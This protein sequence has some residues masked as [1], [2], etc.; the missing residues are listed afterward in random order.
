MVVG[1]V[2]VNYSRNRTNSPELSFRLLPKLNETA[3]AH[4]HETVDLNLM[5]NYR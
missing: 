5:K 2:A 4:V 3:N 1:R